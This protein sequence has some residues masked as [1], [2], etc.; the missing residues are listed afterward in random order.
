LLSQLNFDNIGN[1]ISIAKGVIS[2]NNKKI[3]K[4]PILVCVLL[5]FLLVACSSP[6]KEHNSTTNEKP[7]ENQPS[8]VGASS[9]TE[10]GPNDINPVATIE[11]ESGKIIKVELFPEIAPNTVRNFISLSNKGFYN[12]LTFHRIIPGFMIQGGDPKGNGTGGPDYNIFGEFSSNGFNNPLKHTRGVIS[13][14]R[15]GNNNNSAGSQFFI[16]HEDYPSL[17]D[18]YAAFGN[19]IEGLDTVDEIANVKTGANDKPIEPVKIKSITVETFG[20]SY[21]DVEKYDK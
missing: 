14:A 5:S 10:K 21:K 1:N 19:V 6:A 12:G 15:S 9:P 3:L 13:M 17:D 18:K 20:V 7:S 16:M 8:T 11:M 2:L 4:L